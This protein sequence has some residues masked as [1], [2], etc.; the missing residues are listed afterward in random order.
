M[1]I[2]RGAALT[3]RLQQWPWLRE[4][5]SRPSVDEIQARVVGL[6]QLGIRRER[7]ERRRVVPI[8][9]AATAR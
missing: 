7:D 8:A 5:A 9:V 6:E 2:L 1:P 4:V 3:D